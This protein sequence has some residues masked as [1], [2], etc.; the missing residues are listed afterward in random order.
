MTLPFQGH[1]TIRF[2][3]GNF[4][5]L[6]L[7]NRAS[8]SSRFRDIGLCPYWGHDLDNSWSRHVIIHV[9]IRF[10]IGHFLFASS[11]SDATLSR[12]S[13]YVRYRQTDTTL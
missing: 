6:V 1:V 4:L 9:I 13:Q 8:I 7:R 2:A 12:K 10:P 5:L 3:N 11:D